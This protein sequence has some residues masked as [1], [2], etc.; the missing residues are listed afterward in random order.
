MT[1]R[2]IP[3]PERITTRAQGATQAQPKINISNGN[4]TYQTGQ[5]TLDK[6]LA[7]ILSTA[8][9]AKG[10][11]YVPTTTMP[12]N[13]QIDYSQYQQQA[14]NQVATEQTTGTGAQIEKVI[15]ENKGLILLAAGAFV[16]LQMK[17]LS[18]K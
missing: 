17:P 13:Q 5:T 4:V 9:L 15:Q 2:V 12:Q 10:A 8:A 18:R 1:G 14:Y 16:L 7:T 3:C 11:A 6:I